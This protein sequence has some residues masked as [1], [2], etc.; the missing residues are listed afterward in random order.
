MTET[1]RG[2]GR[3]RLSFTT[4]TRAI[5]QRGP[6]FGGRAYTPDSNQRPGYLSISLFSTLP[7]SLHLSLALIFAQSTAVQVIEVR[8]CSTGIACGVEKHAGEEER[9]TE[10]KG[11]TER[12]E[13][14]G[15]AQAQVSGAQR[16]S[17]ELRSEH[18]HH[19][20]SHPTTPSDPPTPTPPA[21]QR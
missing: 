20:P 14:G 19:P 11:K 15:A 18:H 13:P 6:M 17:W 7:P 4:I 21:L 10:W 5:K 2:A 9:E 12:R 16:A 8:S 3:L 1:E